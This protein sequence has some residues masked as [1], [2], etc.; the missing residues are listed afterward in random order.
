MGSKGVINRSHEGVGCF[1]GIAAGDSGSQIIARPYDADLTRLIWSIDAIDPV[2][3]RGIKRSEVALNAPS[4]GQ[5]Q[6]GNDFQ[7]FGRTGSIGLQVATVTHK[8][9]D[10][11]V[12]NFL[13]KP[14]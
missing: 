1:S 12:V 13:I 7:A 11:L 8:V 14:D 9:K 6:T 4:L 10:D 3:L 5:G 2:L